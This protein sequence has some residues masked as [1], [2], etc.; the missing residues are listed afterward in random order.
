MIITRF[1]GD[2]EKPLALD[3]NA[4]LELERLSSMGIGAIY[5]R[6]VRME[7]RLNDLIETLRLAL[8]GGGMSPADAFQI[9]NS[10][11]RNR[12]IAESYP[13]AVDIFEARWGGD[14][15]DGMESVTN[16]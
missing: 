2:G 6:L 10:Y 16:D 7:F 12:P 14:A 1:L 13:L 11:V 5:L 15:S 9:T 3:D 8:I 4:I